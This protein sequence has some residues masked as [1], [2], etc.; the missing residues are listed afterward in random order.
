MSEVIYAICLLGYMQ[1]MSLRLLAISTAVNLALLVV[2][3]IWRSE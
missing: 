3:L 1:A 2:K